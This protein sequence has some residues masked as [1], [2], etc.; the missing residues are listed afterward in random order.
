MVTLRLLGRVILC[1]VLHIAWQTRG[2]VRGGFM[3]CILFRSYLVLAT[4]K[5]SG[6]SFAVVACI[7]LE[8]VKI[9]QADSGKGNECIVEPFASV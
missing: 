2:S 7:D 9:E 3:V 1:G 5:E 4:A 8:G 6:Q